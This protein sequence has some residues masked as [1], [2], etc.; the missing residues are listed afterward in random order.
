MSERIL[1]LLEAE[2]TLTGAFYTGYNLIRVFN[3][4]A[5]AVLIT[6][7]TAGGTTTGSVTVKAGEVVFVRKTATET[8]EAA[9]GVKTV[10]VAIGD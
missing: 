6:V 3:D 5:G 1:K 2:R 8:I 4:T 10:P 9:S 7:K